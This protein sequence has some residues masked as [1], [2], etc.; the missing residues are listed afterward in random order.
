[1]PAL[2]IAELSPTDAGRS[3]G[4]M[5]ALAWRGLVPSQSNADHG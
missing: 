4:Q 1:V 5:G 2:G 3:G